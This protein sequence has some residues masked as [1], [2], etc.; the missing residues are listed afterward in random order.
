MQL[1][2]LLQGIFKANGVLVWL[3]IYR[4]VSTSQNTGLIQHIPDAISVD[5]LKKG[6]RWPG[7]LSAHFKLK[8]GGPASVPFCNALYA[9]EHC[10]A[11][12]L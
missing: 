2:K 10:L 12:I 11:T 6:S 7:S 3:L 1:L 4:I 9:Y 8:Y 5:G